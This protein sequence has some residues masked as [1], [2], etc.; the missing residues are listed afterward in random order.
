[1]NELSGYTEVEWGDKKR[2]L[3]FNALTLRKFSEKY[4]LSLSECMS[5]NFLEMDVHKLWDY[6]YFAMTV[7]YKE[8][9]REVDFTQDDVTIWCGDATVKEWESIWK[10]IYRSNDLSLTNTKKSSKSPKKKS[11]GKT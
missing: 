10:A 1:M 8:D 7:G 6:I 11:S 5:M 9:N 3:K 2:P 4:G